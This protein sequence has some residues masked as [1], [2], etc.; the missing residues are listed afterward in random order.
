MDEVLKR[1]RWIIR[2]RL[3]GKEV[4]EIAS[5]LRICEKTVDRWWRVYRKQGREGLQ[6][7]SR[8]NNSYRRT[9][10]S[11]IDLV[12]RLRRERV[13]GPNRIEGYLRNK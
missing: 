12:L 5:A 4:D 7:K 8:R 10:Q 9:P 6:V 2:R 13:W 1:R 3:E 11:T